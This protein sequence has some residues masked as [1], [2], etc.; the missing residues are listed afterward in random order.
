M[1]VAF[2]GQ[3]PMHRVT[4]QPSLRGVSLLGRI[5]PYRT[6]P[7]TQLETPMPA[8][9]DPR[10]F[11]AAFPPS[12][13][14]GSAES[15][16][17]LAF[18]S[19]GS[20][21]KP[22]RPASGPTFRTRR[23]EIYTGDRVEN[24]HH[25]VMA[26]ANSDPTHWNQAG[27]CLSPLVCGNR[28]SAPTKYGE[29][30]RKRD[31]VFRSTRPQSPKAPP[32]EQTKKHPTATVPAR[33]PGRKPRRGCPWILCRGGST[34]RVRPPRTQIHRMLASRTRAYPKRGN[35]DES[36]RKSGRTSR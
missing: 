1:P 21:R 29:V 22:D 35:G 9:S 6:S 5:A 12:D 20:I 16:D 15:R 28:L 24:K 10:C 18:S 14:V 36:R 31:Q 8:Y 26:P 11:G 23:F 27:W 3:V 17:P 34:S 30:C 4:I 25:R 19:L 7:K 13:S 32:V 33:C 2:R